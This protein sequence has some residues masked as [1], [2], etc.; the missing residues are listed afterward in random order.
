MP[1]F[2][3][4]IGAVLRIYLGCGDVNV[5]GKRRAGEKSDWRKSLN[6]I[7]INAAILSQQ[8]QPRIY[9]LGVLWHWCCDVP[10]ITPKLMLV[11]KGSI[12]VSFK[13]SE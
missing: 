12:G 7:P 6:L 1:C 4:V 10:G 13:C 5:Q 11:G 3:P 9:S 8:L 2:V